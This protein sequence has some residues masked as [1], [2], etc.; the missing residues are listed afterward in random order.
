MLSATHDLAGPL[1][2]ALITK[3]YQASLIC[4]HVTTLASGYQWV[5]YYPWGGSHGRHGV[6]YCALLT[7][8]SRL[9]TAIYCHQQGLLELT[10]S[11]SN[12]T[13]L[14]CCSHLVGAST[15]NPGPCFCIVCLPCLPVLQAMYARPFSHQSILH[16]HQ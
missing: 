9:V 1:E 11:Q 16:D 4:C 2:P 14:L 6:T 3:V 10:C 15:V 13:G 5:C 12:Y 7:L 8:C